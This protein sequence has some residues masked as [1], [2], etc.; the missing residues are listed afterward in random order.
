MSSPK[1]EPLAPRWICSA[2]RIFVALI[3]LSTVLTF[4]AIGQIYMAPI[5]IVPSVYLC[6]Y[7]LHILVTGRPPRS[8]VSFAVDFYRG[9]MKAKQ[10]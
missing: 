5:L 10:K 1:L 2:V 9:R 8:V 3:P 4:I 6:T 7:S